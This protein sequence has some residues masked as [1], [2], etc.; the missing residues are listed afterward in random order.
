MRWARQ[1]WVASCLASAG[2]VIREGKTTFSP[3]NRSVKV[4]PSRHTQPTKFTSAVTYYSSTMYRL[5]GA[6]TSMESTDG[7]EEMEALCK[8]LSFLSPKNELSG[9]D[10]RK[11]YSGSKPCTWK[12][13]LID[14]E[15]MI[16]DLVQFSRFNISLVI[17]T[18]ERELYKFRE[19]KIQTN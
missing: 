12:Y 19:K 14:F 11:T 16:T 10:L 2:R 17:S 6:V 1:L 15:L 13:N 9:M 4:L 8:K 5:R 18:I 7:M 3:V